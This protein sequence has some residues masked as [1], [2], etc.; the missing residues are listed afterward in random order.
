MELLLT[1]TSNEQRMLL[2]WLTVP[3]YDYY[4]DILLHC[5]EI[6]GDELHRTLLKTE[7]MSKPY[8]KILAHVTQGLKWFQFS[9]RKKGGEGLVALSF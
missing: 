7:R 8:S 4:R 2:F 5:F 9:D 3:N 1:I 6:Q